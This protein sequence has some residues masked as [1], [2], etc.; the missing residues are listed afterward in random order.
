MKIVCR[1]SLNPDSIDIQKKSKSLQR[2]YSENRSVLKIPTYGFGKLLFSLCLGLSRDAGLKRIPTCGF[3]EKTFLLCSRVLVSPGMLVS[4]ESGEEPPLA[5][6]R[7]WPQL[8]FCSFFNRWLFYRFTCSFLLLHQ[9]LALD[10]LHIGL[11]VYL[12][13]HRKVVLKLLLKWTYFNE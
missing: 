11:N 3:D 5:S 10:C 4:R 7:W 2:R 13:C 12:N 1:K 9:V 6:N 8:L